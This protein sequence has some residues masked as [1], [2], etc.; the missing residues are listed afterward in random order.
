MAG[1]YAHLT[2]VNKAFTESELEELGLSNDALIA[3]AD[4][5]TFTELGSVSPDYPYLA[6]TEKTDNDPRIIAAR[7]QAEAIR[8]SA[9]MQ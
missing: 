9:R 4:Y 8:D 6:V 2:V 3:L 7:I 1:A 5:S